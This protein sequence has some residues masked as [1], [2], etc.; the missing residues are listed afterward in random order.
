[1][2]TEGDLLSAYVSA[3]NEQDAEGILKILEKWKEGREKLSLIWAD[4]GYRR[5]ALE[6]TLKSS[7]GIKLT[8]TR[9]LRPQGIWVEQTNQESLRQALEVL[10]EQ[11][12][13]KIEPRRW[14]VE[15]TLA[16]LGRNRRLSKDYEYLPEISESYLYIA[17]AKILLKR[18][19]NL[20]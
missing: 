9:S 15:R 17:M 6:E 3:A 10:S 2:D 14:V 12:K 5:K 16:W 11:R 19:K 20:F 18:L 7:Y 8:I 1:M 4:Q 13:F